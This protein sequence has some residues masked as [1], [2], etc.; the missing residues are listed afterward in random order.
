MKNPQYLLENEKS[1]REIP[2]PRGSDIIRWAK[3]IGEELEEKPKATSRPSMPRP[4][5][6]TA[7][8]QSAQLLAAQSQSSESTAKAQ[9]PSFR[10]MFKH[11]KP[12]IYS[13]LKVRRTTPDPTQEPVQA[14]IPESNP[15][16]SPLTNLVEPLQEVS[17]LDIQEIEQLHENEILRG[18]DEIKENKEINKNPAIV[19]AAILENTPTEVQEL[20]ESQDLQEF[21][22][23][24]E[25]EELQQLEELAQLE[26]L[27]E[28]DDVEVY[29]KIIELESIDE[30]HE[31]EVQK[32]VVE[33]VKVA[34]VQEEVL[35]QQ[36]SE[37]TDYQVP[38]V[39]MLAAPS[40]E[41][42]YDN[43]DD[44]IQK[45]LL[46]EQTLLNFGV[47]V[48]VVD[49]CQGPAITR[50]EL[51]PAP[52]IKVSR[53]VGLADDIALSL[54]APDVRIEAPVPGKAVVGIEVPND[55]VAPV[56]FR[57][58]IED[59][60]FTQ[61]KSPLCFAL[62]K[63][64]G[65]EPVVADLARMPHLLIAGSTGSGKSVCM[66]A[67]ITSIL[68]RARPDQVKFLMIDPKMVELSTYNG[69]P[70][71]ISPVIIDPKKATAALKW[72]V[73]EMENR[74]NLFAGSGARNI[75]GYNQKMLS[76]GQKP[77]PLI[78]VVI[79]ELADLMM[80]ASRDVEDAICRLAQMARAAGIHLV[81]ATQRPS[82]DVITGIIKANIPSRIAFAVSSQVD[83]RT[84]LDMA[85]AEKLLG[86]GD[87]L[88]YP[89]GVP[90]PQRVQGVFV[91][92]GEIERLVTHLKAQGKP[93]YLDP[94]SNFEGSKTAG[95]ASEEDDDLLPEAA[96][97]VIT[98]GQASVS[99]IQRR[100]RVGYARAARLIDLLEEKGIV[101]GYEGSKPREVLISSEDWEN[102]D[103]DLANLP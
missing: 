28:M 9:P 34:E 27:T 36:A 59:E 102:M 85:G 48:Q 6:Q 8:S 76:L 39:Q 46:L 21:Q 50:F 22:E 100:L 80:V 75:E 33:V 19:Q 43:S 103:G 40:V 10:E 54:A 98:S 31:V 58:V 42:H 4:S 83:S 60:A 70:H 63:D 96:R 101:G 44:V 51:Q 97:I 71:L 49:F 18:I 35:E 67:L 25:I 87:M 74:Y 62:G 64:I 14:P 77:L 55:R 86:R 88:F 29:E 82:V 30:V 93:E 61:A 95:L 15:V 23:L 91:S 72:V 32:E 45:G 52:G 68:F 78:V 84:I 53:I 3:V 37:V 11:K 56:Y 38:S 47:K 20:Q 69:I 12:V 26:Q 94:I 1:D 73:S 66:N 2:G 24:Q 92:D 16:D 5:G 81:I 13:E 17:Q 79:D 90:K 7:Q 65:G 41:E 99:F 57:E 89:T